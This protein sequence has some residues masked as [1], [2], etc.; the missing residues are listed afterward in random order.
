MER[1]MLPIKL[2][3]MTRGYTINKMAECFNVTDE[4]IEDVEQG[5]SILNVQQ[6]QLGLKNL[7]ISFEDYQELENF[8]VELSSMEITEDARYKFM[9]IKALGVAYN[10]LKADTEELLNKYLEKEKNKTK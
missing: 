6:L 10:H 2:I 8:Y 3:R 4:Y 9:L 7:G 5:K 1:K